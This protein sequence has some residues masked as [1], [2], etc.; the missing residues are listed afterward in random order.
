[1]AKNLPGIPTTG[2][3]REHVASAARD[4]DEAL[5]A[6]YSEGS[7][8]D[9]RRRIYRLTSNVGRLKE[10]AHALTHRLKDMGQ[11]EELETISNSVNAKSRD[12]DREL[13]KLANFAV[14][15]GVNDIVAT[16]LNQSGKC[17]SMLNS[18]VNSVDF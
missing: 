17:D 13:R 5:S 10:A 14:G 9:V 1:M 11:A 8:E 4:L 3:L 18:S 12:V 16:G 2:R 6:P 7:A 15:L